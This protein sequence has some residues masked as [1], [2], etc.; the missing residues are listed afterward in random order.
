MT[1]QAASSELTEFNEILSGAKRLVSFS[2]NHSHIETRLV[3]EP[4][5][6][7]MQLPMKLMGDRVSLVGSVDSDEEYTG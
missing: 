3:I 7:C 4:C 6:K 2:S 5:E 1:A